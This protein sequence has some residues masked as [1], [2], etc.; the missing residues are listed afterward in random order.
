MKYLSYSYILSK[1]DYQMNTV[2]GVYEVYYMNNSL[3]FT[4]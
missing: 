1:C 3:S 2:V 4:Y